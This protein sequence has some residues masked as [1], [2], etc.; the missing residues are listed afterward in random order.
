MSKKVYDMDLM[1][2]RALTHGPKTW[3]Q[4]TAHTQM[5]RETVRRAMA[6]LKARGEIVG[7][8]GIYSVVGERKAA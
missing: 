2:I 7:K 6:R 8:D 5:G 1:V 4:L 3:M